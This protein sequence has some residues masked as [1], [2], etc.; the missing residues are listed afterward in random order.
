MDSSTRKLAAGKELESIAS[1]NGISIPEDF[2]PDIMSRAVK[3]AHI[4]GGDFEKVIG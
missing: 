3:M 4:A 2:P 1:Q